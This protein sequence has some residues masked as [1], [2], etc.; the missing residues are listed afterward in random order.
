MNAKNCFPDTYA[1]EVQTSLLSA[2]LSD[3]QLADP[4]QIWVPGC[5]TGEEVYRLA[6]LALSLSTGGE[7]SGRAIRIYATDTD[8]TALLT[9]VSGTYPQA[10]ADRLPAHWVTAFLEKEG[11]QYTV[12]PMVRAGI[13]FSR[14]DAISNSQDFDLIY[15]SQ[16]NLLNGSVLQSGLRPGAYLLTHQALNPLP[17]GFTAMDKEG[18]ALQRNR[19]QTEHSDT[20]NT[21]QLSHSEDSQEFPSVGSDAG[22]RSIIEHSP[23][24]TAIF[25]ANGTCQ[26]FSPALE[27]VLGFRPEEMLGRSGFENIHPE[28]R[29]TARTSLLHDVQLPGQSKKAE[30]RY[31]HKDGRYRHLET[32]ITN[33][34]Q[35]PS[36]RGIVVNF[37]DTTE[38]TEARNAFIFNE[39]RFRALI[40]HS[41]DGIAMLAAEGTL[42]DIS[43]VG[44]RLLGYSREEL[45]SQQRMDLF[46]P[47]D[48]EGVKRIFNETVQH[49]NSVRTLQHRFRKKDHTYVWLE[50]VYHNLLHEP[51]VR[52][53]VLNFRDI[54]ERKWAESALEASENKYKLFFYQN[55]LPT[56][57]YDLETLKFLE[58]ND[59]AIR[60]YGYSRQE[61]LSMTLFDIRPTED[62]AQLEADLKGLSA[63]PPS[64]EPWRHRKKDGE[65]I[66]VEITA[67]P[68]DYEN[69]KARLILS[70]NVTDT[71]RV[72]HEL[73]QRATRYKA[74]FSNNPS[75]MWAYDAQTLRF[76]HVNLAAIR[77]YGYTAEEFAAMKVTDINSDEPGQPIRSYWNSLSFQ[78]PARHIRKDGSI[79]DVDLIAH[80]VV[81]DDQTLQLVLISDISD[82]IRMHWQKD[83][84][85]ATLSQISQSSSFHE[86]MNNVMGQIRQHMG[87]EMAEVWVPDYDKR[88]LRLLS[89]N[90]PDE[91]VQLSTFYESSH[92]L[93]LNRGE[94]LPG[95]VWD[96]RQPVWM[97]D[98]S[99][100]EKF[101]RK[102]LAQ[103]ANFHSAFAIPFWNNGEIIALGV[104]FSQRFQREDTETMALLHVIANQL[105]VEMQRRKTEEELNRF[106]DLVPDFLSIVGFDG[107][108]RKFN[109]AFEKVLGYTAEELKA[110]PLYKLAHPGD[111][112]AIQQEVQKLS[113]DTPTVY[114]EAR[115]QC[116]DAS[117]RWLSWTLTLLPEESTLFAT[118]RDITDKKKADSE[119]TRIKMAVDHTL[120][121]IA[122]TDAHTKPIYHNQAYLSLLGYTPDE[123]QQRGFRALYLKPETIVEISKG[124]AEEERWSGDVQMYNKA[125]EIIDFYQRIN[126]IK[127]ENEQLIGYIIHFTDL[128]ERKKSERQLQVYTNQITNILQRI[129]DGFCTVN[130]DWVIEYV[131]PTAEKLMIRKHEDLVG[132]NIWEEFAPARE[133]DFYPKFLQAMET[134]EPV[135]FQ[136]YY[137]PYDLWL[138][139]SAYPSEQ[140][141][142]FYFRDVSRSR[143]LQQVTLLEKDVLE[144]N[145]SGDYPIAQI[146]DFFLWRIE[147]IN[148]AMV[149]AVMML[150]PDGQHLQYLSAPGLPPEY[151]AATQ[152]MTIS[153]TTASDREG[154]QKKTVG[155]SDIDAYYLWKS[156]Q[157]SARAH[158]LKSAWSYPIIS[159]AQRVV[160]ILSVYYRQERGPSAREM[161]LIERA[162]S[163]LGLLIENKEAEESI[164]LSNE[165]YRIVS[166]VTDEA[167]FDW[168]IISNKI[169]W[170]EGLHLRFGY[171]SGAADSL[172]FWSDHLHPDDY[173]RVTQ[174]LQEAIQSGEKQR[175][176]AE[177]QFRK[178]D[179]TYAYVYDRG[180]LL[181]NEEGLATR[182]IGAL[183]DI[184]ERKRSEIM[185]KELN[186]SLEKRA[187][188]LVASN[189]ELERFAYVASH[190]L[191]EPLRMVRSF[192]QLLQKKYQNQLDERADEYIKFAVD[193]ADTMK[194]LI[195]D[196]LEY[197]RVGT[198]QEAHEKVALDSVLQYVRSVFER[199]ITET[200]A[201]IEAP[202]L[203]EINANRS[204][205]LQLFQNLIGN[206][207]KY[208]STLPPCIVIGLEDQGDH[209]QFSVEDNGIGI[210]K[211]FYEKVF[212]I[213]QRLHNKS[214]YSGTGI[215]LA[216]CKKIVER[217]GGRIW[218]ESVP[219][220]GSTFYFT[221]KK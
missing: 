136:T 161:T 44:E 99:K 156:S 194:R 71:V 90:Y 143:L 174:S 117:Y 193:G 69:R 111:L 173:D 146:T 50:G 158:G 141:L 48:V 62:F 63:S 113:L 208:R 192:L 16:L 64:Q 213:F 67:H 151:M 131:N 104:F 19:T 142:S 121:A 127:D 129:T 28:D 189:A 53:V 164:R 39:K 79:I 32:T 112:D 162:R 195:L 183:Q 185:L 70:K 128:R 18:L 137:P 160:A 190:D 138:D 88:H 24:I 110:A 34:L 87:W 155:L 21:R 122:I 84:T 197:S 68:I 74:L 150:S 212:I 198:N 114:F 80:E 75:P 97:E 25:D 92:K 33:H 180:F 201:I 102:E 2:L 200:G 22:F 49:P 217:H 109:P 171:E 184:T 125:G 169:F 14:T 77:H 55:P 40:E 95:I 10:F 211:A 96:T 29:V 13:F 12:L 144:M 182:M 165:R 188:E 205:L 119:L 101:I 27:A 214:A 216:I 168:D 202:L 132:K 5:G 76:V 157:V 170:G 196:L 219:G 73:E 133:T 65:I 11:D 86:G 52:A 135:R 186:E 56:W 91:Q 159:S 118:A 59:V 58:V 15:C 8:L 47:D 82:K 60:E 172:T 120:D 153:P 147:E 6:I 148:P 108:I 105:G 126:A 83:L 35:T 206:A 175:W 203:P 204:Q 7:L 46:H 181:R 100:E 134:Q 152:G 37:R 209:W 115:C 167:I 26:Y 177:Y 107:Y 23:D 207:L 210:D 30:Y 124:I 187:Q 123:I 51:S 145:I 176:E 66:Q 94:S 154:Y 20:K 163:I 72:Q 215:G 85:Y 89:S 191:Q 43:T 31:L 3:N 218:L 103:Q 106:F 139:V 221:L 220:Q 36:I 45:I 130:K 57:I 1:S 93:I 81:L 149:C 98:I 54:T 38:K 41:T 4:I 42:I 61:F 140:A 17:D 116:K 178:A 9:A 199:D 166:R 179:N 78:A